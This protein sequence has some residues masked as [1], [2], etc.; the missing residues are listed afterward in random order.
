M[1]L[2][3]QNWSDADVGSNPD[4]SKVDTKTS[5]RATLLGSDY[6]GLKFQILADEGTRVSAGQP[7]ICDR[8]FPQVLIA[9]PVSG[10]V[11]KVQ[12]GN[13]RSLVA[14]QIDAD[15][16]QRSIDFDIPQQLNP[17]N[18]RQLMQQAGL[19]PALRSRPFG[20]VPET[21]AEPKALLIS[22]MDTQPLAPDPARIIAEYSDL[23]A[24]GLTLLCSLVE[25][26]IYLCKSAQSKIDIDKS[27]RLQVA[28]FDGAHPAGLVGRHIHTLCPV[29]FDGKQVWH[30]G[31]QDVIS[32]GHL[33]TNRSPWQQRVVSLAGSAVKNPRLVRV[34]LGA[35]IA[36]ITS[37]ELKEGQTQIYSGSMI[38]GVRVDHRFGSLGRF[39]H[40]LTAVS[41]DGFG[42]ESNTPAAALIAIPELDKLAPPGILAVPL[43]RALLVG[44]VERA[45]ELG[46]LEL[47]EE[48]L[49]LLSYS[50]PTRNDYAALLR[51]ML[52]QIEREGLSIRKS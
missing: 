10:V 6:R 34:P 8:R 13:R 25:A 32:L 14:L 42:A 21:D 1:Q 40:Q 11:A 12:R 47:V 4:M 23:F 9:S 51:K 28:E 16:E 39:H 26:P 41:A 46:A 30:I 44:D 50:C 35:S 31:Y 27:P 17:Q 3:L 49:A 15:D 48:D 52:E 38:S 24:A 22:A 37:S 5:T 45:L 36:D 29:A 33:M 20:N 43:L 7:V 2:R 19:W 18:A